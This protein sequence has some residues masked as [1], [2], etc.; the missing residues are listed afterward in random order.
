MIGRGFF[1]GLREGLDT[2]SSVSPTSR[3]GDFT[4]PTS[5][6]VLGEDSTAFSHAK[7]EAS[8][9]GEMSYATTGLIARGGVIGRS[10]VLSPLLTLDTAGLFL[11]GSVWPPFCSNNDMRV[12]VGPIEPESDERSRSASGLTLLS[13]TT[14]PFRCS[15]VGWWAFIGIEGVVLGFGLP[16]RLAA[17]VA[18]MKDGERGSP[19]IDLAGVNTLLLWPSA[20]REGE[21]LRLWSRDAEVAA[22]RAPLPWPL[23]VSRVGVGVGVGIE[24]L[25]VV[26][27]VAVFWKARKAPLRAALALFVVS[28][29]P[30]WFGAPVLFMRLIG[31]GVNRPFSTYTSSL[32]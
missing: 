19:G 2:D 17:R 20:G 3:S 10:P 16:D 7:D 8:N 9:E 29:W 4:R 1:V 12:F 5:R 14:F 22:I 24:E 18:A 28:L 27:F 30:A 6:P 11:T 23:P 31:S 21:R 15:L 25:L 32:K 26:G 13:S